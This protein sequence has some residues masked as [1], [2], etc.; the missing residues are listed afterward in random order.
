MSKGVRYKAGTSS[1]DSS[2]VNPIHLQ[3]T[4]LMHIGN[5]FT[6]NVAELLDSVFIPR[7]RVTLGMVKQ[8]RRIWVT[9]IVQ[10][11][12]AVYIRIQG[13]DCMEAW[14]AGTE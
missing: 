10:C 5:S 2:V 12:R 9:N 14:S 6:D 11:Y 8:V 4:V 13:A 7:K 1:T 3:S